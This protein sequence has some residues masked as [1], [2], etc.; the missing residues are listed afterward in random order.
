MGVEIEKRGIVYAADSNAW[1][2][3]IIC[4]KLLSRFNYR[5]HGSKVLLLLDNASS[6]KAQRELNKV[7][8]VCFPLCMTS[9]IQPLD[10]VLIFSQC[11]CVRIKSTLISSPTY[12]LYRFI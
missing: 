7:N 9:T 4:D 12:M 1:I 6:Q 5:M 11:I 2:T 10:E 3:V 8:V